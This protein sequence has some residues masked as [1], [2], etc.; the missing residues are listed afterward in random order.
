MP[1][2]KK[3]IRSIDQFFG[4]LP[5]D[6]SFWEQMDYFMED[7][8]SSQGYLERKRLLKE[9]NL[10]EED[11]RK[12]RR[13]VEEG[14]KDDGGRREGGW[15]KEGR[16]K[17][18]EKEVRRKD[19]ERR[20]EDKREEEGGKWRREGEMGEE[21]WRK[22]E[23]RREE[24][25]E[26]EEEEEGWKKEEKDGGRGMSEEMTYKNNTFI[27]L[28]FIAQKQP[29][30]RIISQTKT[31]KIENRSKG[32]WKTEDKS[33]KEEGRREEE[34]RT[35]EEEGG[36]REDEEERRENEEE[37]R[38]EQKEEEEGE[39]EGRKREDEGGKK[40]KE[41]GKKEEK[42]DKNEEEVEGGKREEGPR[43]EEEEKYRWLDHYKMVTQKI[44]GQL[45][46]VRKNFLGDLKQKFI[47]YFQDKYER[48]LILDKKYSGLLTGAVQEEYLKKVKDCYAELKVKIQSCLLPPPSLPP[49]LPPSSS[50]L[51]PSSFLLPPPSLL[52]SYL[53]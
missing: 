25:R 43:N 27:N 18:E 20:E 51:H 42:E 36:I 41:G 23:G 32:E 15:K 53:F 22:E 47:I 31:T 1:L 4:L 37:S 48:Q 3:E 45:K 7:N 35:K 10:L 19:G 9:A 13:R 5:K 21:G 49:S 8:L 52:P 34:G 17:E 14:R 50:L 33:T 16:K 6:P 46:D 29:V 39:V 44:E 24:E 28:D 12:I 11:F 26:E 40:E 2:F 38:E 30:S